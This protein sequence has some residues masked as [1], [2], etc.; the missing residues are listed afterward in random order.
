MVYAKN[1][2]TVSTFVKVMQKKNCGL[3]F[4]RTRCI[5]R[6]LH[7]NVVEGEDFNLNTRA[8]HP[9]FDSEPPRVM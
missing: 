2:E 9:I 1:Y 6:F 5:N 3:F 7:A 8:T 4:S